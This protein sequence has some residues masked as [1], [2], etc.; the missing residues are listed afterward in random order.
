MNSTSTWMITLNFQMRQN[1]LLRAHSTLKMRLELE[2]V[3][4][5]TRSVMCGLR[6]VG[7]S[8]NKTCKNVYLCVYLFEKVMFLCLQ[9]KA[10]EM[11]QILIAFC[12]FCGILPLK[13]I[14]VELL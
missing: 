13:T 5:F 8:D 11:L 4:I 6:I 3:V 10:C 2:C 12:S 7:I 14:W 1:K 9:D